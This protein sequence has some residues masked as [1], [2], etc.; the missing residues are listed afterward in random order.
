[1]ENKNKAT[2]EA[3]F[4]AGCFWGIED[5]FRQLE[6]VTFTEVGYMGGH[7]DDPSYEGVCGGQTG[8]AETVHLEFDPDKISY[9]KLLKTFW[10]IHDPTTLNRQGPDV[11]SQYRSVIFYYNDD[12]RKQAEESK[13]ALEDSEKYDDEVVTEIVPAPEFYRA[14]EYHQQY[15]E[16]TGRRVCHV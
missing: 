15:F 5:A 10:E 14:E 2:Q 16:K 7:Q 11:G 9:Q 4:A 1:M 12:Q 3:A 13:T 8:H 6:G